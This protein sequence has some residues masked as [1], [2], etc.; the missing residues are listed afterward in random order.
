V[1]AAAA[2]AIAAVGAGP[3][4]QV[5][6]ASG[7]TQFSERGLAQRAQRVM[8]GGKEPEQQQARQNRSNRHDK[9]EVTDMTKQK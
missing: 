8:V 7:H 6:A 9:T 4:C 2:S 1:V 5:Q 3:C